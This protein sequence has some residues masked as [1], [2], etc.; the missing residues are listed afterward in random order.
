MSCHISLW[1]LILCV[2][3]IGLRDAQKAGK[4][5]YLAVSIRVSL[6]RI[7]LWFRKLSKEIHSHVGW[8]ISWKTEWNK[9]V[10]K[11]KGKSFSFLELGYSFS[12]SFGQ[13]APGYRASE[14]VTQTSGPLVLRPWA[15]DWIMPPFFL[16]LRLFG[17]RSDCG[18]YFPPWPCELISIIFSP[19]LPWCPLSFYIISK[20][21]NI[22]NNI[23]I[24]PEDT[25]NTMFH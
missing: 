24:H 25:T 2:N 9:K 10:K 21:I 17:C 15:S 8:H 14:S 5:L 11:K 13:C 22:L 6:K 23:H 3:F 19:F 18:D 16:D 12:L 20:S 4:T 1:W 7:N